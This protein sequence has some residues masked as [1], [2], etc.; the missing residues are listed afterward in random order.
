M[1]QQDTDMVTT[2]KWVDV[3]RALSEA[4]ARGDLAAFAVGEEGRR[5]VGREYV[6]SL[7]RRGFS[8]PYGVGR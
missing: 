7:E 8:G 5:A 3:H 1:P 2:W 4:A 6:A